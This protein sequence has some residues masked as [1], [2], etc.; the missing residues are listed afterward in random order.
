L[1]VIDR[2]EKEREDETYRYN[3]DLSEG[4]NARKSIQKNLDSEKKLAVSL[5]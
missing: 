4:E 1:C 3:L 5:G 2:L